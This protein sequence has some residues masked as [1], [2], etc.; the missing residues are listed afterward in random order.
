MSIVLILRDPTGTA[1]QFSLV[2]N[3]RKVG[4]VRKTKDEWIWD[5]D[6]FAVGRKLVSQRRATGCPETPDDLFGRYWEWVSQSGVERYGMGSAPTRNEAV[7]AFQA[8][9]AYVSELDARG[10]KSLWWQQLQPAR[11]ARHDAPRPPTAT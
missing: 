4:G 8:T 10:N 1:E 11:G 9:W 7:A 5:V 3:G 6:W 2:E